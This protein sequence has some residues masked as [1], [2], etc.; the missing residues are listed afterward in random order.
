MNEKTKNVI[1]KF[2]ELILAMLAGA[3]S[4]AAVTMM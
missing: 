4:G 2:I 1:W 3:G